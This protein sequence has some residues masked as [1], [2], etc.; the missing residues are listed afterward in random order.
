LEVLERPAKG[1][2]FFTS[3]SWYTFRQLL[4][5][6]DNMIV[7]EGHLVH[8]QAAFVGE[9]G[10]GE[11]IELPAMPG[12]ARI[13]P[14]RP[15]THSPGA[16]GRVMPPKTRTVSIVIMQDDKIVDVVFE[17]MGIK[18]LSASLTNLFVVK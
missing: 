18:R 8:P 3:K 2:I 9:A 16:D 5:H 14:S 15:Q 12:A 4:N 10:A 6:E 17:S 1:K 13:S 7:L 11:Q